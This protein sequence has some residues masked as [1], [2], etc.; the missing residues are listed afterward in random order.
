MLPCSPCPKG[1]SSSSP[2]TRS[3]RACISCTDDPPDTIAHKALAV[4]LS[5]L[6]AKG[7]RPLRLSVDADATRLRRRAWLEAFAM[8]LRRLQEESGIALVGGDTS[9]TL[10]PLTFTVTATRPACR[11]ARR[12]CAGAPSQATAFMSAA[13]SAMPLSG[14]SFCAGPGPRGA[15][16]LSEEE[17]AFLVDRYRR[18]IGAQCTCLAAA[19]MRPRGDR[20]L[21]RARRR[22]DEAL[23]GIRRQR[24]DRGCSAC[25]SRLPPERRSPKSLSFSPS[26]SAAG[27]DY[28]IVAAMEASHAEASRRKRKRTASR[29]PPSA[30]SVPECGEVEVL[31]KEGRALKLER[32][33][34]EHFE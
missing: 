14:L 16:G 10:G 3:S 32:N 12:C 20:C 1:R 21:R 19:S 9:D 29:S 23:Q 8:G 24:Q 6:A 22:Y 31:D 26:S 33:G 5:D 2:A 13:P 18:R 34:F 28:E 11:K 27:D 17:A 15:W 4:S 25:R 30:R 7:A